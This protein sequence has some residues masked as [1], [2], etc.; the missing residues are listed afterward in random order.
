MVVSY[1]FIKKDN[2]F[3]LLLGGRGGTPLLSFKDFS[4]K[5]KK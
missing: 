5:F 3:V 2:N 1:K 4:K